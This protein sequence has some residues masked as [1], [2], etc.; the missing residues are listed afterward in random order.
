[1]DIRQNM[2]LV[3]TIDQSPDNLRMLTIREYLWDNLSPSH[4]TVQ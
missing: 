1:M 3:E 4:H 2:P